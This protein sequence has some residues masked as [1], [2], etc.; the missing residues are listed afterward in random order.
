MSVT[1]KKELVEMYSTP[2]VWIKR[3]ANDGSLAQKHGGDLGDSNVRL[4]EE[5]AEDDMKRGIIRAH[6]ASFLSINAIILPMYAQL[7]AVDHSVVHTMVRDFAHWQSKRMSIV[8]KF[9]STH[10]AEEFV[11]EYNAM[12]SKVAVSEKENE[13]EGIATA[14]DSLTINEPTGTSSSSTSN[15]GD[16]NDAD[17]SDG[18]ID[19]TKDESV[20]SAEE[21]EDD[22]DSASFYEG[23]C[24]QS[25][26][27]SPLSPYGPGFE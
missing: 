10:R 5:W 18:T 12:V 9:Y 16:H 17:T 27:M 2:V 8:F 19:L 21:E 23:P 26:P 7:N 1:I 25:F 13:G 3:F 15:H 20:H 24:T 11:K 4:I 22:N 6:C 14:I